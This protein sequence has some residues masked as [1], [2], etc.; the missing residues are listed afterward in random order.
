MTGVRT[1][2]LIIAVLALS[3]FGIVASHFGLFSALSIDVRRAIGLTEFAANMAI[4]IYGAVN[5]HRIAWSAYLVL[6]VAGLVL[7]SASTPIIALWLA[8]KLL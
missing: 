4:G 6:S 8:L 7:L 2:Y 3:P 1:I 5:S